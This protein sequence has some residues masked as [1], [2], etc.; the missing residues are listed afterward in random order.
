MDRSLTDAMVFYGVGNHGGGPTRAN[1]DSIHRFDRMGSFGRLQM[2][3]PREYLDAVLASPG[4]TGSL[5]VR[6]DDLQHH[7]PGCY[8][9]HSGVKAW[10]RRAQHAVLA[11]ERWSA[12]VGLRHG[13]RYPREDLTRAWQQVLFNQFHDVLPGSA[14]QSAYDDARDQLGEATAIA[15][16]LVVRAHNVL[17]RQVDVPFV[18]GTQPVLVFNPHAWAVRADVVMT[19]AA[20]RF[21]VRV[22]DEAGRAVVSQPT[23]STST[24]ADISRGAVVFR[25]D[26]PALG[27]RLYRLV[28][29]LSVAADTG[30][31]AGPPQP[32]HVDA[33]VL[34]NDHVRVEL[35]PATGWIRVLPRPGDRGRRDGR[36]RRPHPHPGLRRP[37]RHLGPPGRLLRLAR[38]DDGA[39]P[40][41]RAGDRP[42]ALPG[43]RRAG[44]G[45][46]HPRRGAGARPRQRRPP[47]GGHAG[48]AGAG[49][50]AQA[51]LPDRPGGAP[52]HLRDP[53]RP[54]RAARRRRRGAGPV[55]GRPHRH[56]RRPAGRAHRRRHRQARLR[57]LARAPSPASG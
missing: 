46:L 56:G 1:I 55:L 41:R 25:A 50:P 34:A 29:G 28:P 20:Q 4:L 5:Q 23:Q 13:R 47:G 49:A 6:R 11:A 39:P 19:Y 24:T 7:A 40:G 43:P 44:L 35:D 37:D 33:A 52:G 54:P 3:S 2:A 21:G 22:V 48:L 18:E 17:A 8:S 26:V 38:R 53:V 42:A 16:R 14:I 30:W 51:A 27:Y 31:S 9:A 10:Q 45:C 36:R 15:K 32:L 12:V 57:R